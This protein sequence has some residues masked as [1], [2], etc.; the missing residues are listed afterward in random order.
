M[1]PDK[2]NT[3]QML[4]YSWSKRNKPFYHQRMLKAA[5]VRAAVAQLKNQPTLAHAKVTI[6][7]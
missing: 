1:T 6:F 7:D 2:Q 5:K 4:P 3:L